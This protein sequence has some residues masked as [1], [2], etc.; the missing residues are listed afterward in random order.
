MT[1]DSADVT[2]SFVAFYGI[3]FYKL[4][5]KFGSLKMEVTLNA[6]PAS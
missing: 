3:L 6:T 1:Y 2:K 5:I 4:M